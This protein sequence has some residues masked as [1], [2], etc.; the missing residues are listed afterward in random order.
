[1]PAVKRLHLDLLR[2]LGPCLFR[3]RT[4][5]GFQDQGLYLVCLQRRYKVTLE[6]SSRL[7][8]DC[9]V[10]G[11]LIWWLLLLKFVGLGCGKSGTLLLLDLGVIG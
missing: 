5:V 8:V 7:I 11:V 10:V 9:G 6:S 3:E 1:M 4:K 2:E